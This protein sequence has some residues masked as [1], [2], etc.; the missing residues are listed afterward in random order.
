MIDSPSD[1][2]HE[3][4]VVFHA[5]VAH[6]RSTDVLPTSHALGTTVCLRNWLS[7]GGHE[8]AM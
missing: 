8:E 7:R 5:I 1:H 4:C 6:D 2:G 3:C